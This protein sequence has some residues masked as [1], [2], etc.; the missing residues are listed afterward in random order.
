MN[1]ND[2]S[3]EDRLVRIEKLLV[4][5][6]AVLNMEDVALFTGLSKS[7]LY[8]LT[9]YGN[10]PH[11]KPNGKIIYFKRDEIEQWL[12]KNRIKTNEEIDRESSSYLLIGGKNEN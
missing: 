10:I 6:K 9:C 4:A 2:L 3:I 5:Q 1:K 8:K 12:L 7:Y 11:F